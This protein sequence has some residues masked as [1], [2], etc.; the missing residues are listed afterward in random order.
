MEYPWISEPHL[1]QRHVFNST[2]QHLWTLESGFPSGLDFGVHYVDLHTV[3]TASSVTM[4]ISWHGGSFQFISTGWFLY[5]LWPTS[6]VSSTAGSYHQVLRD[7][8][9]QYPHTTSKKMMNIKAY[10]CGICFKCGKASHWA[11]NC[12]CLDCWQHDVQTMGKQ[13]MDEINCQT[14]P[15]QITM[16]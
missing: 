7:S 15:R 10:P 9:W 14:L 3:I 2:E 16:D 4:K 6:V 8:T 1:A 13:D 12:P 11:E 5:D